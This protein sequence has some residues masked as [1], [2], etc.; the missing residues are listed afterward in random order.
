M[1]KLRYRKELV[2]DILADPD[3]WFR[4]FRNH[5]FATHDHLFLPKRRKNGDL[6]MKCP[7]HKETTPSFRVN[8]KN[9]CFKCF[10]CN[11]GGRFL[12]FLM[13]FYG[14]TFPEAIKIA[15]QL[16]PNPAGRPRTKE[17]RRLLSMQ[18]QLIFVGWHPVYDVVYPSGSLDLPF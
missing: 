17:E 1:K 2:D 12:E 13:E 4:F 7:L 16:K 11:K 3:Y 9:N 14:V 15:L 18:T 10:G 8:K 5:M 6:T